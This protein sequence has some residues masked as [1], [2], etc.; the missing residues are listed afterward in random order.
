MHLIGS[1]VAAKK[2]IAYTHLNCNK[3]VRLSVHCSLFL[4]TFFL[5]KQCLVHR[6]TVYFYISYLGFFSFSTEKIEPVLQK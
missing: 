4:D 3:N 6:V 5:T 1:H 2:L